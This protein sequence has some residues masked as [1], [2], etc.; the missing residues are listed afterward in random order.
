MEF[1]Y[2]AWY[3][4]LV[5]HTINNYIRVKVVEIFFGKK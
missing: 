5:V 3:N 2:C 1:L 4:V